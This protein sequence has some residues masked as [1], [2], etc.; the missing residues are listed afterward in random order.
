MHLDYSDILER[1]GQ[2]TYYGQ[3][4][5][6]RYRDF[7]PKTFGVFAN[8]VA[9]LRVQ[10]QSCGRE[11]C[12]ASVYD[13]TRSLLEL[14]AIEGARD[15]WD[16][17]G[18]FHYGEPPVHHCTGDDIASLPLEVVEFWKREGLTS[19]VR[20]PAYEVALPTLARKVEAG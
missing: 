17:I 16:A 12:V 5:V 9:K 7:D 15:P 10:C 6:P 19:W 13:K 11:F 1:A 3:Y 8:H 18:S 2:P 4:G 14:P 20:D